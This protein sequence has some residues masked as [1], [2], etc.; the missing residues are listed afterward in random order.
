MRTVATFNDLNTKLGLLRIRPA[1]EK[2]AHRVYSVLKNIAD[3][4][5]RENYGQWIP[6]VHDHNIEY[7]TQLVC[8]GTCYVVENNGEIIGTVQV[9]WTLPNYWKQESVNVGYISTLY[10]HRDLA[11]HDIGAS[12]LRWSEDW[13]RL[14]KKTFACLHCYAQ[15]LK[16]CRYYERHGYEYIDRVETY[17]DYTQ[18]LYQKRL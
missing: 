1:I 15:N 18:F 13:I 12:I 7:I 16:L 6:G 11:G 17:P 3:W 9:T 14:Q 5:D 4:L 10:V 8:N 2:D